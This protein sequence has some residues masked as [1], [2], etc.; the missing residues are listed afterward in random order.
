MTTDL[1]QRATAIFQADAGIWDARWEFLDEQSHV[2]SQATGTQ[3]MKFAIEERVLHIAMDVPE[4]GIK[5]VSHRFFKPDEGQIYWIS[6]DREGDLWTFVEDPVNRT[7]KSLPHPNPDG[8]TTWLRFKNTRE[9]ENEVDVL[10]E[11]STDQ[12]NW[13]EI[14]R[15]FRVRQGT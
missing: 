3:T 9:T 10:M 1:Q 8:S 11:L 5:S 14:F 7:A 15:Q 6:V 12:Q 13:N 4:L 2:T